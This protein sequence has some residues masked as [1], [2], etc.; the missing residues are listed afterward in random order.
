MSPVSFRIDEDASAPDPV[1]TLTNPNG[2]GWAKTSEGAKGILGNVDVYNKP[3]TLKVLKQ[4]DTD[5]FRALPGARF[6]L[7]KQVY[8]SIGGYSK[9]A[10]PMTEYW[11]VVTGAD[12]TITIVSVDDKKTLKPGTYYLTETAAPLNYQGVSGDIVF[13]ISDLGVVSLISLPD[14]TKCSFETEDNTVDGVF[15]NRFIVK[16]TKNGNNAELTITKTVVGNQG[17]KAK[18][19]TFTFSVT[20]DPGTTIEYEWSKNGYVQT[21]ALKSGQTFTMRHDDI[22]VISLPTNTEVT[23]SENSEDYKPSFK[24][25]TADAE[26]GNTKTFTVSDDITLAFTNTRDG[27]I[28]TGIWISFKALAV[29][30]AACLAGMFYFWRRKR[31]TEKFL[32]KVRSGE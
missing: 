30:G 4:N 19:F 17:N 15:E 18:D 25:G 9:A 8:T 2:P 20:N 1:I 24:L 5:P 23:I 32:A 10:A 16:N 13:S 11:D 29:L 7:Y 6:S 28:P 22:V 26:D 27:I 12:G 31:K 3:Y 14:A 21:T